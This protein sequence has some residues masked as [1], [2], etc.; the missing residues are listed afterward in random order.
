MAMTATSSM[1]AQARN[2][3]QTST[4]IEAPNFVLKD[5]DGRNFKLSDF[6]GRPI[7]LIFSTTWC[8]YCRSEIPHFKNI[9][10]TYKAKGLEVVNIDINESK[11]KVARFAERYNLPYRVVI[12]TD[13]TVAENYYVRGVPSMA[14]VD[15]EG[16]IVCLYCRPVEPHLERLFRNKITK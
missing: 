4:A 10:S 7:L 5:I 16:M 11:E 1:T 2:V 13:G 14:L 3:S 6:K 8:G 12:D 9:Y 15:E